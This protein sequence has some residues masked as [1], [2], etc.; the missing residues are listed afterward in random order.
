MSGGKSTYTGRIIR[1]KS[2]VI[3]QDTHTEPTVKPTNTLTT[4]RIAESNGILKSGMVVIFNNCTFPQIKFD[5]EMTG[6][7]QQVASKLTKGIAVSKGNGKFAIFAILKIIPEDGLILKGRYGRANSLLVINYIVE[8]ISKNL[9]IDAYP[10][11][12]DDFL[13][14]CSENCLVYSY[15]TSMGEHFVVS[16]ENGIKEVYAS[17]FNGIDSHNI[18][19]L[20]GEDIFKI[21]GIAICI[22]DRKLQIHLK[23]GKE[24][25]TQ[26]PYSFTIN[27]H[28]FCIEI[29]N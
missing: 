19:I 28:K 2:K 24:V 5:I 23:E 20:P 21:F 18:E 7:N 1:G 8:N 16:F 11:T 9:K 29:G 22:D 15:L 27:P 25:T 12:F 10:L 4:W 17:H 3:E 13:N 6:I 26:Y 14:Y